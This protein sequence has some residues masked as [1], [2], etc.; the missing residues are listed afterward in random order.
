MAMLNNQMVTLSTSHWVIDFTRH[1][2]RQV[3]LKFFR[4]GALLASR[5][6]IHSATSPQAKR[7]TGVKEYNFTKHAAMQCPQSA[8]GL[9]WE[10]L[11]NAW[12]RLEAWASC[13]EVNT[14]VEC[15]PW[16]VNCRARCGS[17]ESAGSKCR[18]RTVVAAS[19][20]CPKHL[21]VTVVK[22]RQVVCRT[23]FEVNTFSPEGRLFQVELK[24]GWRN[25]A[26][27]SF[28]KQSAQE[29]TI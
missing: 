19:S 26:E 1:A 16:V 25:T 6:G 5:W 27:R 24:N 18:L 13:R 8:A 21:G 7:W 10:F 3:R 17:E 28:S 2:E 4:A 12:I 20:K 22:A 15:A 14:I 11:Q 9:E 23:C 29:L